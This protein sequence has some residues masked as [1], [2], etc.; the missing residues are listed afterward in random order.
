M[1]LFVNRAIETDSQK[2]MDGATANDITLDD[3]TSG[4]VL[5]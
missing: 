5:M 4:A 3:P 1:Y 2:P